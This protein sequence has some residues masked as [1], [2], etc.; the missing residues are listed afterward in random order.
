[1]GDMADYYMDNWLD[2]EEEGGEEGGS[3]YPIKLQRGP[4][5]CPKCGAETEMKSGKYGAFFGCSRFP[6]CKG[7]R[8]YR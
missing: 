1:M 2:E 4:G 8:P 7:S 3:F 6:K 5:T